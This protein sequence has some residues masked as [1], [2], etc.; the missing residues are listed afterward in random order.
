MNLVPNQQSWYRIEARLEEATAEL[1]LYNEISYYGVTADDFT[2]ELNA[3]AVDNI[4]VHLNSKGG[5][6]F[7]GIAIYNA[8]RSHPANVTIKVDSL[9]ASIASVILQAA[10]D[11]VIVG[12]G[13]V[14]I[15]EASGVMVGNAEEMARFADLL[16]RQSDIIAGIY[17]ERAGD[18]RRKASFR[19]AM[20]AETW[21]TDAEAVEMG[22]AD[23]I[24]NTPSSPTNAAS[25]AQITNPPAIAISDAKSIDWA[26]VV[27]ESENAFL[28]GL[29]S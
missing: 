16:D 17:A 22:L 6:V 1:W 3:L 11:R 18:M 25:A 4:V 7:D 29:L 20:K 10:D 23:R 14:M 5:D 2:R 21:F 27:R 24:E 8:L 19:K 15:H 12:H 13:Q 28:E 9:A 26:S